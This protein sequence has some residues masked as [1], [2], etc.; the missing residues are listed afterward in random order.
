MQFLSLNLWKW[1]YKDFFRIITH[2][3]KLLLVFTPNPEMLLLASRKKEF[4]TILEKADFLVPDGN[5]LYV[6]SLMLEGKNF[7]SAVYRTY[8][9]RKSISKKYGEL[10]KWSDLTKDI[11][12]YSQK[13]KKWI[14]ILDNYR[15]SVAKNSFEKKKKEMQSQLLDRIKSKYPDTQI[16]LFFDGEM[17]PDAIAHFIEINNIAYVLSCIGMQ[18]QESRL[19]EIFAYLPDTLGVVGMGVGSSIDYLV[20]IQKRAPYLF[21]KLGLEWFY[22]LLSEPYKRWSRILDAVIEFP[23]MILKSQWK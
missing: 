6:G 17:S 13:E 1:S 23:K 7:F 11:F 14:L 3:E 21:Q 5:G 18:K 16:T 20:G 15:I 2:T 19:V 9:S 4:L 10:I 12:Q 8:F 22:R